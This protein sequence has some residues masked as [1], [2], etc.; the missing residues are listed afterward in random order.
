MPYSLYSKIIALG[1]PIPAMV[2]NKLDTCSL[3]SFL[4]MP[5]AFLVVLIHVCVPEAWCTQGEWTV[6]EFIRFHF[7]CP[8]AVPLFFF[9][10]GFLFF[11]EQAFSRSD[12]FRKLKSRVRTLLLPYL[13][14]ALIGAGYIW[15]VKTFNLSRA[16]ENP[17]NEIH[18]LWDFGRFILLDSG[19]VGPLWF[20]RHLFILSLLSPLVFEG[21]KRLGV[22]FVLVAGG[23]LVWEGATIYSTSLFFWILGAF[24]VLSQKDIIKY[25]PTSY[26]MVAYLVCSSIEFFWRDNHSWWH[27]LNLVIG[28]FFVI[29]FARYICSWE[30]L[31]FVRCISNLPDASYFIYLSHFFLVGVAVRFY[32]L[33]FPHHAGLVAFFVIG[34]GYIWC[35]L[36][37]LFFS[38]ERYLVR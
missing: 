12:Y 4:R 36:H 1:I 25:L 9:F 10:S 15:V 32:G 27:A 30:K 26:L 22:W 5:L 11:R 7:L 37:V 29:S 38:K 6:I 14:F 35:A 2:K 8:L 19:G 28:V 17:Y 18:N 31:R 34:G 3:V 16:N 24:F 13:V 21:I 20:L 23:Y 33:L